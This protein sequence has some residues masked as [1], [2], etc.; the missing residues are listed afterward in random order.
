MEKG[1]VK[2]FDLRKNYGFIE[3]E[4]GT[5]VFVHASEIKD[6]RILDE[7]DRVSFE[8]EDAPRGLRAKNVVVEE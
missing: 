8:V 7:G 3:R 1:T 2:W 5:D 6:N 4:N